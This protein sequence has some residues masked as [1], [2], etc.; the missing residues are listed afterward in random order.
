[1]PDMLVAEERFAAGLRI[2][3]QL[4]RPLR[5]PNAARSYPSGLNRLPDC[6]RPQDTESIHRD[7]HMSFGRV[8]V[9]ASSERLSG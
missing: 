6:L 1:M 5:E 2:A 8:E 7:S 3:R 4:G 9:L